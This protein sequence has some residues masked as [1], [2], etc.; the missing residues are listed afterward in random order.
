[1][2]ATKTQ[3]KATIE[4]LQYFADLEKDDALHL[5]DLEGPSE[6]AK[7]FKPIASCWKK[8]VKESCN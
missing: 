2:P 8:V 6:I 1:M 7:L 4:F 5:L 3:I